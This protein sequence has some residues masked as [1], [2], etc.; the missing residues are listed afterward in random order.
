MDHGLCSAVALFGEIFVS[1]LEQKQTIFCLTWNS[2]N[3]LFIERMYAI[4]TTFAHV[5]S[6]FFLVVIVQHIGQPCVVLI[7]LYK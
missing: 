1:E 3:S 7:V 5:I 4:N 6:I 2:Q